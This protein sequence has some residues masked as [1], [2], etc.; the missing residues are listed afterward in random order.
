MPTTNSPVRSSVVAR[1]G[2]TFNL[3][4]H[5][6]ANTISELCEKMQLARSTVTARIRLL[7]Q[8]DLITES[9]PSTAGKGRSAAAYQFNPQAGLILAA[10]IGITASRAAITDLEGHI[11]GSMMIDVKA[12][13]GQNHLMKEIHKAFEQLLQDNLSNGAHLYGIGI[14]LPNIFELRQI[15]HDPH[16][17]CTDRDWS[18]EKFSSELTKKFDVSVFVD[19][20]VN[21]IALAE[22][23]MHKTNPAVLISVKAGSV[24]SCGILAN[25]SIIRGK[26]DMVGEI[27]HTMVEGS[28][29]LCTCGN[30]GCLNATA[31]GK[32]LV[33]T[34]RGEGFEVNNVRDVVALA[35]TGVPQAI[36][37]IRISGR[38]IGEVLANTVNLLNPEVICVW[39]YLAEPE[40]HLFA[41]IR[42]AL[43]KH[44]LPISAEALTLT[45]TKLKD[46][47]GIRGASMLVAERMLASDE[48]EQRLGQTRVSTN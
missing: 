18:L 6:E 41:G 45:P 29:A 26:G 25:G 33:E 13:C 43:A 9:K 46:D 24:I 28:Q 16:S 32:A 19:H 7:L 39:G 36:E 30:R 17:D 44:A 4:R 5:K 20:D 38:K 8:S 37:Q 34:L 47:A 42:E 11:L 40:E 1:S 2:E 10:Q 21:L 15:S 14:G 23:H 48:V 3:I 27:G 31:G 35:K 12:S 22:Q